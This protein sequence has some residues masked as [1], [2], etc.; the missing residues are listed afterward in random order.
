MGTQQQAVGTR[1]IVAYENKM[2]YKVPCTNCF[3]T[4]SSIIIQAR[5]KMRIGVSLMGA[6]DGLSAGK[7]P[8]CK[9]SRRG[10]VN[11]RRVGDVA[12]KVV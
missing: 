7:V 8:I 4:I 9:E 1:F 10:P 12:M 11:L 2:A 3:L 5:S 6:G